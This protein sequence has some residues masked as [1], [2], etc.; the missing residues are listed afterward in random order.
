MNFSNRANTRGECP[1]LLP[2]R[3]Q[4][5]SKRRLAPLRCVVLRRPCEGTG[6]LCGACVCEDLKFE[7][8]CKSREE[9]LLIVALM[10]TGL[11]CNQRWTSV[12]VQGRASCP[13]G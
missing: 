2:S 11:V 13:T 6:R 1:L 9:V 12:W 4:L 10:A 5:R 7:A 8:D 3:L